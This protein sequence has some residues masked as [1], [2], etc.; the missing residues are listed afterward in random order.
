GLDGGDAD[1][2][3][4]LRAMPVAA[5]EEAALD[6]DREEERRAGNQLLVVEISAM[7]ARHDRGDAPP[8]RRR[9]HAHDAEERPELQALAP[10]KLR[11]PGGGVERDVEKPRLVKI[12]LERARQ[13]ADD[14]VA[15]I[16]AELHLV[17]PDLEHLP[18][19]CPLDRDRPGEDMAR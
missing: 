18:R 2:A 3:V 1:L 6:E 17:N 5:G 7:S 14:V 15:P 12:V 4:A 16:L 13:G 10:G 8:G 19:P 9:R 11:Q